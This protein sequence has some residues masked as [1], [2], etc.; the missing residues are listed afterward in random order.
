M[1][2]C[3]VIGSQESCSFNL[4]EVSMSKLTQVDGAIADAKA[5][6]TI[7]FNKLTDSITVYT[8]VVPLTFTIEVF[9]EQLIAQGVPTWY[10]TLHLTGFGTDQVVFVSDTVQLTPNTIVSVPFPSTVQA[11]VPSNKYN[12]TK[13]ANAVVSKRSTE[14]ESDTDEASN[15]PDTST[16]GASRSGYTPP[17][18]VN[19]Q[20]KPPITTGGIP[21]VTVLNTSLAAYW[22]IGARDIVITDPPIVFSRKKD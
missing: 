3:S 17:F 15:D 13:F 4:K 9:L 5:M 2:L 20:V 22:V 21:E 18:T 12:L 19:V 1:H 11:S 6:R 8:G 7:E 10:I 16:N 14:S